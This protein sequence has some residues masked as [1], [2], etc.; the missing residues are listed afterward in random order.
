MALDRRKTT[1]LSV[2]A[3]LMLGFPTLLAWRAS[4]WM[5]TPWAGLGY[6]GSWKNEVPGFGMFSRRPRAVVFVMPDS[7]A[8]R[9]DIQAGDLV[10]SIGGVPLEKL[11]D[12]RAQ[13]ARAKPG[14]LIVYELTRE[15]RP[16]RAS[17]RLTS[18]LDSRFVQAELIT[19]I[20]CGLVF[21]GISFLVFWTKPR[22]RRAAVFYWMCAVGAAFFFLSSILMIDAGSGEG[23]TPMDVNLRQAAA[24]GVYWLLALLLTN[25]LLHLALIFP[26]ERPIL[27]RYPML[28]RWVHTASFL[29]IAWMTV[30]LLALGFER[31][32]VWPWV[33]AGSLVC[34]VAAGA[35]HLSR[36][37]S[38]GW[39]DV[40]ISHPFITQTMMLALAGLLGCLVEIVKPERTTAIALALGTLMLVMLLVCALVVVYMVAS[41]AALAFSYRDANV[42]EKRQ[43]RWPLWGTILAVGLLT[44]IFVFQ[45]LMVNLAPTFLPSHPVLMGSVG[46]LVRLLYLLIPISFAFAILKYR[47]MDIDVI[48]K[49]TLIY[50]TITGFIVVTYLVLVAVVGSSLVRFTG[51]RS[52]TVTILSTLAIAALFIPVRNRV[53]DVCRPPVL[54]PQV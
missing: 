54:S 31:N 30:F 47:L 34:G 24:M 10:Q 4:G 44:V 43:I 8:S 26:K 49:K 42:E 15:G 17:V 40:M 39:R 33:L 21:L 6:Y 52:Q 19:N 9:A 22:S 25:L 18:V 1:I 45:I 53:Q 5:R 27:I 11:E 23:L 51:V 36:G 3:L 7:P 28:T 38:V 16:I 14:D 48:I 12:L 37:R 20:L 35:L 32:S 50:T 46:V 29:P 41:V 13:S 2:T